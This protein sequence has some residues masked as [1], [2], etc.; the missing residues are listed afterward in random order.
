MSLYLPVQ[1]PKLGIHFLL[2]VI[3]QVSSTQTYHE[4]FFVFLLF[5]FINLF[6]KS[7]RMLTYGI[8]FVWSVKIVA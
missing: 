3:T 4:N 5:E 1:Y 7:T 6:N 8:N 2:K